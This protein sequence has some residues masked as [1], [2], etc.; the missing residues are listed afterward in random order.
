MAKLSI[1]KAWE[2][3]TTFLGRE[4]RLVSPV[5]LAMFMIPGALFAWYNPSGDPSKASAGLGWPLTMLVL[6][7][8]VAGQMAIAGLAIGWSGS[9]GAALSKA[10]RGVWGVLAAVLLIFLPLTVLLVFAIAIMIGGSGITDP[11]QVTAEALAAVPGLS[12]LLLAMTLVFL[13]AA[14]RLFPLSAVG[15]VETANPLRLISRCWQLT[16]GHFLRLLGTLLLFLIA[17][18]V[19]SFAITTVVGSIM[20][21][22]AGEPKP[23][24]LSALVIALADALISA[25]ISAVSAALVGRIYV[26]LSAAEARVPEVNRE[27]D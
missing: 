4:S 3:S 20:E 19:A 9:V 15:M 5:A 24:N 7:L 10:L 17:G 16:G 22:V 21:L 25:A 23:F 6:I 1:S 27:A 18:L 26:Q 2:E 13:F 12:F 8:A 11:T 14:V